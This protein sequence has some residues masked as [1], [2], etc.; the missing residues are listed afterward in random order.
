MEDYDR[1]IEDEE[2]DALTA[3]Q[4]F[5]VDSIDAATWCIAKARRAEMAMN[6]RKE[7]VARKFN[8]LQRWLEKEN[9]QDAAT[10][11]RMAQLLRPWTIKEIADGSKRSVNL[12]GGMVGFRHQPARL[13]VTNE[14]E[15]I[16][17]CEKTEDLSDV[18]KY[19]PSVSMTVLNQR[20]KEDGEILPGTEVV[21]ARDDFYIKTEGVQG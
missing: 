14:K 11:E 3:R 16:E 6:A 2:G 18:I 20:F 8:E 15:L 9:R 12:P 19:R 1:M 10:V 17:H 13:T 5:E 4:P 7:Y 21:P